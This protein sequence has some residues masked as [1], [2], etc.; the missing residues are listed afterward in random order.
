MNCKQPFYLI[1]STVDSL[2]K[3][4]VGNYE[5]SLKIARSDLSILLK[6][7]QPLSSSMKIQQKN[8]L[9]PSEKTEHQRAVKL[10]PENKEVKSSS[11]SIAQDDV[12]IIGLSGRFAKSDTMDA[13]WEHLVEGH[14]L[15]KEVS[16][17]DLSGHN[18]KEAVFCHHGSFLK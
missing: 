9:F 2:A 11:R 12:A 3:H 7:D 16:R 8:R 17:W 18:K 4:I 13:F 10:P 14:D 15:I 1:Y 5:S 6:E